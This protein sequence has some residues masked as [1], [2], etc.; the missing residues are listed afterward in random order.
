MIGTIVRPFVVVLA[1]FFCAVGVV[2]AKPITLAYNTNSLNVT[3]P[4]QV[5]QELGFF[6]G[7]GFDVTPV[8]VRSGPTAMTALVSGSADYAIVGSTTVVQAIAK[9]IAAVVIGNF[10]R[11]VNWVLMGGS[12]VTS[13]NA[14]KGHVVGV[15][16]AGGMTEFLT[17]EALA[18][19]GLKRDRDYRVHYAGNSPARVAALEAK[20]IQAAAFSPGE[21]VVLEPKGFSVL[22]NM[23]QVV[24]EFPLSILAS[25]R[26]KLESNP[27]EVEAFLRAL[28][29]SM[30]VI[31]TDRERAITAVFKKAVHSDLLNERKA[32][33]YL[34]D[35]YS[36]VITKEN[37][38]ALIYAA[39]VEAEA[40]KLGGA[41]KFFA[42]EPQARAASRR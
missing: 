26:R 11:Q 30:E 40:R 25:S 15:T 8:Y 37:I 24:P 10:L 7:E 33:D 19:R 14:I 21:R 23:V 35:D 4:I 9:G 31:R 28:Q 29:R 32:L 13:L 1:F 3:L 5:A 6:T 20:I 39:G 12:G 16:S 18:R 34:A 27:T 17:V 38:Q 36:I 41:E 2:N 42:A 22:M